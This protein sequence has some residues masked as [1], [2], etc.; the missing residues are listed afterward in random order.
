MLDVQ[1]A[2]PAP[3]PVAAPSPVPRHPGLG[4]RLRAGVVAGVS[5]FVVLGAAFYVVAASNPALELSLHELAGAP[6]YE[7]D[8]TPEYSLAAAD[9]A[10]RKRYKETFYGEV[11]SPSGI[12]VSRAR[13]IITGIGD[14]TR[15]QDASVRIGGTGTY[16]AITRLR[17]GPY[18]VEI[19]AQ[20]DGKL[21]RESDDITLRNNKAY[22]ASI[23]IRE[24][25]I[26]TMLPISSY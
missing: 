9:V 14:K 11:S 26:I 23:R 6:S 5:A 16:R 7:R 13:L 2:A 17:P 24:S 19:Q 12:P 15:G 3:A 8:L 20:V 21:R 25:G 22:E 10:A 4:R 1:P 18:R